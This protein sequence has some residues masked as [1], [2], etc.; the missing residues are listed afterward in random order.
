MSTGLR[1]GQ[2]RTSPKSFM[3]QVQINIISLSNS[4]KTMEFL[5]PG[6]LRDF[7]KFIYLKIILS[8]FV[9]LI[10]S[11]LFRFRCS[12]CGSCCRLVH[13]DRHSCI[14]QSQLNES[15]ETGAETID[16]KTIGDHVAVDAESIVQQQQQQPECDWISR[17]ASAEFHY[18]I[19][20]HCILC[21]P[22]GDAALP[23]RGQAAGRS[24]RS[25]VTSG[26]F[27]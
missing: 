27:S 3:S 24:V 18:A 11:D 21:A 6:V 2:N 25:G 16:H 10:L 12:S 4:E 5:N 19:A 17:A 23:R 26:K 13:H 9:H 20:G 8:C 14:I 1:L 22:A 7:A 15:R